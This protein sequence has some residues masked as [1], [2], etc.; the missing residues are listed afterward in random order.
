RARR[1]PRCRVAI[2]ETAARRSSLFAHHAPDILAQQPAQLAPF[3]AGGALLTLEYLDLLDRQAGH[4]RRKHEARHIV[5]GV[6]DGPAEPTMR[7][8]VHSFV[9]VSRSP[10]S[11]SS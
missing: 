10:S 1:S 2:F 11:S 5:V 9:T 7:V 6:E 8:A 3:H 4:H